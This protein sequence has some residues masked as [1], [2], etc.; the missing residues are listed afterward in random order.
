M[1]TLSFFYPGNVWFVLAT[2]PRAMKTK[3]KKKWTKIIDWKSWNLKRNL[4]TTFRSLMHKLPFP[5]L[6]FCTKNPKQFLVTY[7]V[8]KLSLLQTFFLTIRFW[9]CFVKAYKELVIVEC[10]AKKLVL[11]TKRKFISKV[12]R[13]WNV[14]CFEA[15]W[16]LGRRVVQWF[17]WQ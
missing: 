3:A 2:G 14:V 15:V 13:F 4:A 5:I 11:W 8:C 7:F 12:I 9:V 1:F 10:S 16:Q 17:D 6:V